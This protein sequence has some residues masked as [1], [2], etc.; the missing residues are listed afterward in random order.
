MENLTNQEKT[1]ERALE[2]LREIREAKTDTIP[3]LEDNSFEEELRRPGKNYRR[4]DDIE[5][6]PE[7]QGY[8]RTPENRI[9]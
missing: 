9:D 7:G 6:M 1:T 3:P 8:Y 5:I 4:A 2:I